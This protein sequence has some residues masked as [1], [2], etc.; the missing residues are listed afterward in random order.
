MAAVGAGVRS[1]LVVDIGWA[2]TVVSSVY[3]YREIKHSRTIRAGRMLVQQVHD[4]LAGHLHP[5]TTGQGE[6]EPVE[7]LL[8]FDECEDITSRFAWSRQMASTLDTRSQEGLAPVPE[9]DESTTK[10]DEGTQDS[11][12]VSISLASC[13][14]APRSLEIPLQQLSDPCEKTFVNGQYSEASFDDQEMPLPEL[15]YKHLLSLPI[16]ARA[17]CMS[18]ILFTGG[19]AKIPGLRRRV[20]DEV[21]QIIRN[22]G[23]DPVLGKG[24]DKVRDRERKR[25]NHSIVPSDASG[26]SEAPEHD[27]PSEP[28]QTGRRESATATESV[29][30]MPNREAKGDGGVHGKPRAIESLG[31]WTGASLAMHLK[32][33]AVANIDREIWLQQGVHGASRASDVDMKA[34]QRQGLGLGL[35]RGAPSSVPWT[36]GAWGVS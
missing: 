1:A 7:H 23:W 11:P 28:G 31:P 5:D 24:A 12:A 15:I 32:T 16:D 13:A 14:G 4:M 26:A 21:C 29:N 9:Q 10:H 27:I 19:G 34:Q 33:V 36:L 20:F 22:R 35:L 18:R 17:S 25:R 6:G 8:S 3:E 2:E 30:R